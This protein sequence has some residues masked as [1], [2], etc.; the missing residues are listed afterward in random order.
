MFTSTHFR[1]VYCQKSMHDG[2]AANHLP[3]MSVHIKIS[4]C[5]NIAQ[6]TSWSPSNY[7]VALNEFFS[8]SC[9]ILATAPNQLTEFGQGIHSGVPTFLPPVVWISDSVPLRS[10]WHS[11]CLFSTSELLYI[12]MYIHIYANYFC[13]IS[14]L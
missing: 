9:K 12:C 1:Q 6:A 10:E 7:C 13:N 5:F 11:Y 3:S 14:R 2:W 8:S 4:V